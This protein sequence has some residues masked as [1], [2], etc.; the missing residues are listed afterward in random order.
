MKPILSLDEGDTAEGRRD[1]AGQERSSRKRTYRVPFFSLRGSR[2]MTWRESI[3][4]TAVTGLC[5]NK[6][7]IKRVND[8]KGHNAKST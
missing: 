2:L 1:G 3:L 6:T 4:A 8:K 7:K 5:T